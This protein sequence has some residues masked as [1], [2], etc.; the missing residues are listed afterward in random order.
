MANINP[1]ILHLAAT[2]WQPGCSGNLKGKPK[3]RLNISTYVRKILEEERIIYD[4]GQGQDY[5]G[6]PLQAIV[7]AMVI[8]ALQGD[9]RACELVLRYAYGNKIEN[10]EPLQVRPILGGLTK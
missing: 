3:G 7:R 4:I 8:R 5:D 9:V 6:T 1:P 10:K 2:R